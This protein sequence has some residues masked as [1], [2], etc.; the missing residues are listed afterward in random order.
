MNRFGM[1]SQE[2]KMEL[3]ELSTAE[4]F[5]RGYKYA[6]GEIVVDKLDKQEA[7]KSKNQQRK[8]LIQEAKG[9]IFLDALK[10]IGKYQTLKYHV[11]KDKGVVVAI[12]E[13]S[14][15]KTV[16]KGIARCMKEDVFNEVIGKYIAFSRAIGVKIDDKFLDPVQPDE[17]VVGQI[18]TFA[19]D[20][21]WH[22]RHNYRVDKLKGE[23]NLTVVHNEVDGMDYRIG[24]KAYGKFPKNHYEYCIVNDTDAKY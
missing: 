4:V 3:L 6:M 16:S 21:S 9:E 2:E 18:I 10:I 22:K 12:L 17:V 19:K 14:T 15:G 11:Q 8:E 23:N 7:V 5:N 13:D 24:E 20:D 1:L